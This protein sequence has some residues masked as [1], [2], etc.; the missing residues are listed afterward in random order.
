MKGWWL[1]LLGVGVI[2]WVQQVAA[3]PG[4]IP[5]PLTLQQ[6]LQFADEPHPEQ[7]IAAARQRGA[8]AQLG[9][10]RSADALQIELNGRIRWKT[11]QQQSDERLSDHQLALSA[12]K[13]LYDFGRSAAAEAVAEHGL[14]QSRL[15]QEEQR[16][17]RR[18]EIMERFF[19][20]L[21]ADLQRTVED[22]AMTIA[23]LRFKKMQ[24]KEVTGDYSE[25]D[26]LQ[27]ES[28][29]QDARAR[30]KQA[31]MEQRLTRIQLAEAMNRPGE[32][33]SLLIAPHSSPDQLLQSLQ[34]VEQLQHSAEQSNLQL[35]RSAARVVQAE[36]QLA[37]VKLGDRPE[38]DAAF[39]LFEESR[40]T[41][42]KDRW[43]ASL[44][45]EVPLFDGGQQGYEVAAAREQLQIAR[46]EHELLRR[47]LAQQIA[48]YHLQ[49]TVLE[50]QWRADRVANEH[51][52]IELERNRA[53]YEQEQ[54]SNFGDALVGV[55]KSHLRSAESRFQALLIRA[56]LDQVTGKEVVVYE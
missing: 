10:V 23:Y 16:G 33:P 22:E 49:L 31:E 38:L 44:L 32:I 9:I 12:R 52:E 5:E 45:L 6:A 55:S 15:Q 4:Q 43:R 29:F 48:H 50:A 40:I 42:S 47:Q 21:L 56:R 7:Q 17:L 37:A 14:N 53:L 3:L 18:L 35:Q 30:Q 27:G 41:S 39:E 13:P 26:L 51:S 24:D 46:A 34:G 25:L 2:G 11:L 36:Q 28:R 8:A 1:S 19:A 54:Q 20:V